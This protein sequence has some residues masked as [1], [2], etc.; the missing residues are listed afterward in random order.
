MSLTEEILQHIQSLPD[1]LKA[2]VL[3]FVEY[4]EHKSKES[5]E[6]KEWSA[7]SLSSAMRGMEEELVSYEMDDLFHVY[8]KNGNKS[9]Y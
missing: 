8:Y 9:E 2:E 7:M 5:D 6:E 3:D 1:S 4:L